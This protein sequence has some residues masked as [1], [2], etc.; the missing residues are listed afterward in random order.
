MYESINLEGD[1]HYKGRTK[2]M[3]STA[4]HIENDQAI[5]TW[6]SEFLTERGGIGHRL[7]L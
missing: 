5:G 3:N 6:V 1:S 2:M 7:T 4:L